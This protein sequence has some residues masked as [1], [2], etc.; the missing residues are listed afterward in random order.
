M[1]AYRVIVSQ[2]AHDRM[3]EHFLFLAQVSESAAHTVLKNL[4][5][6]LKSLGDMPFLHP[7]Y[8]RPYLQAGKYRYKL[9]CKKYRIVYQVVDDLIYVDDIQDC[10]QH[11]NANLV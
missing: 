4:T 7:P 5:E 10:R 8:E 2:A 1:T 6:D 9:S 11:D 3:Y